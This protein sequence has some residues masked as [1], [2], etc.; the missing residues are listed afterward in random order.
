MLFLPFFR[1]SGHRSMYARI[2][3]PLKK[4]MTGN[5]V[6]HLFFFLLCFW[7][8]EISHCYKKKFKQKCTTGIVLPMIKIKNKY[9]SL[10][11][12]N[13]NQRE[14]KAMTVGYIVHTFS[15]IYLTSLPGR[16]ICSFHTESQN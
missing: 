16:S 6:S 5:F 8:Q 1:E 13:Y 7:N 4:Y 15:V 12:R 2:K 11:I 14:F 9:I 10:R 3:N